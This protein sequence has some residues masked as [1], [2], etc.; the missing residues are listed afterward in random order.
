[1]PS[2]SRRKIVFLLELLLVLALTLTWQTHLVSAKPL[3]QVSGPYSIWD[4]TATPNIP[5][6]NDPN[7]IELGVKFRAD[8]DGYITGIRFYKGDLN[9]GTHIGN[10]WTSGGALLASATF[11]NETASGWQTV[12][13]ANPV[14]ITANTTYVASYHTDVGFYSANPRYFAAGGVDNPPLHAL[15]N[16]IDG[17]NGVYRYGPTGFPTSSFN[18]T[19]YWVDVVFITD[20]N[21]NTP[22]TVTITAPGEGAAFIAG[23]SISFSGTASDVED[24]DLTANL[25][26]TSSIDGPIGSGGSFSRSDLSVGLHTITASVTDSGGLPGS[27]TIDI[28]VSADNSPPTAAIT[29]PGDGATFNA[30][31][32][33]SF[34]GTASDVEDGDLTANLSWTSSI[35]GPIGGGGSFS[36]SGLSVGL[37]TITASVTDSGGLP[38]SDQVDITIGTGNTA[39]TV[40]ITAPADGATFIPGQSISFSG[41]ASD[42]EDGDLTSSLSWT[43]S[44]DGPIG[45]G[46]SFSTSGLSVGLHTITASVTDSGGLPGSA[47]IDITVSAGNSPPT[48]TNPG[49][50][51]NAEGDSVTLDI[52]ASDPDGDTLTFSAS[53]L[54]SNLSIDTST[55][56]IAGTLTFDSAGVHSVTVTADDGNGG[57]DSI[58]LSW[59]INDINRAPVVTNPGSQTSDEGE[60]VTL[61]ITANDPDGDALTFSASRLPRGLSINAGTGRITGTPTF[62]SA[63]VYN[64]T[65]TVSDGTASNSASF[66]WTVSDVNRAA[67]DDDDDDDD[68]APSPPPATPAPP[69]AAASAPTPAVAF[70]PETGIGG[71]SETGPT[72]WPFIVILPGLG[73][74]LSWLI[75]RRLDK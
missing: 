14:A 52:A 24:G 12:N 17:G 1:M 10:L 73:L 29:A 45:S 25:S 3:T 70:L 68:S 15:A 75:Y 43:S 69:P 44:I 56:Q 19:N 11:V 60:K 28:T 26:W 67:D 50:Q 58:T 6:Q 46:G 31:Q 27:A 40:T 47:T 13:F 72:I 53:G 38:G 74:M 5:S 55:G 41:T 39:P 16:G 57:T 20:L 22:P 65:V 37:H 2:T 21:T 71:Y 63:G 33:I 48:V 51:T 54:P 49:D 66:R 7:A 23:Q 61:N 18:A 62:D 32:S 9:T 59:T 34:S 64:V 36:T 4:D 30:G 42:A 35:D 8:V